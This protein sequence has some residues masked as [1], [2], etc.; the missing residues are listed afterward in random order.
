MQNLKVLVVEDEEI[1]GK[2]LKK[3]IEDFGIKKENVELA[4]NGFEAVGMMLNKRYDIIFL[5]VKMPKF[6]GIK[7]LDTIRFYK[8]KLDNFKNLHICMTTALGG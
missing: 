5:D 1:N 2:I 3:Y 7:V 6:D 4:L 8:E